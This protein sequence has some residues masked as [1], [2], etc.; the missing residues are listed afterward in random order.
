LVL[1][2]TTKR[3]EFAWVETEGGWCTAS[4]NNDGNPPYTLDQTT[5]AI[6]V[7]NMYLDMFSAGFGYTLV[8]HLF[9]VDTG[10]SSCF[11][12]YGFFQSDKVTPKVSATAVRNLQTILFDGGSSPGAFTPGSLS[13]SIT[14]LKNGQ[15][16]GTGGFAMLLQTSNGWFDLMLWNEPQIWDGVANAEITPAAQSVHITLPQVFGKVNVYDPMTGTAPI[17]TSSNVSSLNVS[18]TKDP[19]IVELLPTAPVVPWDGSVWNYGAP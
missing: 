8:Y 9:D 7:L 11:N 12:N 15:G 1:R 3:A 17:A 18:L 6:Y 5:Q 19:L 13:Y 14:G 16:V 10:T 2:I 4:I